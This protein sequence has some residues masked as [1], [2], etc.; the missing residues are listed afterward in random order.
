MYIKGRVCVVC[1]KNR[2][3]CNSGWKSSDFPSELPL[4]V[5]R[6]IRG[7]L[8]RNWCELLSAAGLWW[9]SKQIKISQGGWFVIE[10]INE[11]E[12]VVFR[13]H[14]KDLWECDMMRFIHSLHS[15]DTYS[16]LINC[17]QCE[18]VN[19][20]HYSH[21]IKCSIDK[22]TCSRPEPINSF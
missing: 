11:S 14:Y 1:V 6:C 3:S 22:P 10:P 9:V 13:H 15:F 19:H 12:G 21:E 2:P 20:F 7:R 5:Q 16:P 18:H 4:I 17:L 8:H